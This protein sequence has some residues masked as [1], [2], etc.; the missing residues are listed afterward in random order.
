MSITELYNKLLAKT[1]RGGSLEPPSDMPNI[2][3]KFDN[4]IDKFNTLSIRHDGEG[5]ETILK[6]N[7]ECVFD[8]SIGYDDVC[9]FET[10]D[11]IAKEIKR[12]VEL[13]DAYWERK[14]RI[15]SMKLKK[16]REKEE[17]KQEENYDDMPEEEEKRAKYDMP[18]H[19]KKSDEVKEE[20]KKTCLQ[21]KHLFQISM[22][23]GFLPSLKKRE[24]MMDYLNT[25]G[26]P[27]WTAGYIWSLADS[28]KLDWVKGSSDPTP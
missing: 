16:A 24:K 2:R 3:F 21:L 28:N 14:S 8:R 4:G 18:E 12:L 11:E 7:N 9:Y 10:A 17:N 25:K 6:K 15:A 22:E 13:L 20:E 27:L 1:I 5:Y 23:L 19:W 26:D